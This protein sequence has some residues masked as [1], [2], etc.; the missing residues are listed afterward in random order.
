MDSSSDLQNQ[1]D[2]KEQIKAISA[3]AN[4]YLTRIAELKSEIGSKISDV[5][6]TYTP[7]VRQDI[8]KAVKEIFGVETKSKTD[9]SENA[10]TLEMYTYCLDLIK[11]SG[12]HQASQILSSQL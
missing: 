6:V 11:A 4:G 8:S 5:E 7:N 9:P 3:K 2:T 10:I 1:T 12:Q